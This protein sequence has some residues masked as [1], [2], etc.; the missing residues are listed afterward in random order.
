MKFKVGTGPD[1]KAIVKDV[2][3]QAVANC[4]KHGIDLLVCIGGDGTMAASYG[5]MQRG[6]RVVGVPK[7]I[8]NDL[9]HTDVT[10]GFTTAVQTAT[11][12]IDRLH[13]TASSHHRVMLV[14]VMGRNAGWLALHAGIASGADVILLPE[15]PFDID[16]VCRACTERKEKGKKSTIIAVSEGAK[17]RDG[18]QIGYLTDDPVE[19]LRL[20]GIA[21]ILAPQIAERTDIE[22]RATVLGHV[23]RGGTPCAY[24][25]VLATSFGSAAAKL[26][27][28]GQWNRMVAMQ[29]GVMTSVPLEQVAGAQRLVPPDHPLVAVARGVDT[30]FGNE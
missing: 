2:S 27:A 13:T 29:D 20:G 15:I 8:D 22:T 7:T 23:Q 28:T 26:A 25:R 4:R 6:I 10:F 16:A 9:L 17:I 1:G 24:D 3:D 14:E 11:D 18:Q 19:P 12:A 5:M 30:R 21:N